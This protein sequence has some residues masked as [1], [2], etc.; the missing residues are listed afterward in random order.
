[1]LY[2]TSFTCGTPHV[3][4]TVAALCPMLLFVHCLGV[5]SSLTLQNVR[6]LWANGWDRESGARETQGK[7]KRLHSS[8]TARV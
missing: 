1:M 4:Y 7:R 6:E 8:R 5:N 3:A 2:R